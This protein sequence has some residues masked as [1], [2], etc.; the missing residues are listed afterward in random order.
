M[1]IISSIFVQ[2]SRFYKLLRAL[3]SFEIVCCDFLGEE[4]RKLN[5]ILKLE[6]GTTEAEL[7]IHLLQEYRK[8]Q[9]WKCTCL[10]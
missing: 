4:Y 3:L 5:W 2:F 10:Y 7:L 6:L 1:M 9:K 8:H